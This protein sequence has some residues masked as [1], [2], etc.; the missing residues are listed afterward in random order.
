MFLMEMAD[1]P[2]YVTGKPP[3]PV[4]ES[5]ADINRILGKSKKAEK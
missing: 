4:A 5:A 1:A 3:A 2:R